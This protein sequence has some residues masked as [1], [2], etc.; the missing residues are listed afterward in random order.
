MK[1]QDAW[2]ATLGQLQLQMNKAAFDTWLRGAEVLAYQD[3]T[4]IISVRNAYAKDWLEQRL[5]PTI[6]RTL[7]DIFG[8]PVAVQFKI[9]A[10]ASS[11]NPGALLA[12]APL[13]SDAH[14]TERAENRLNGRYRFDSFVVGASNRLA[15]A[16]ALAVSENPGRAYNPL[17][18]HGGVGLGKTHLLHA[19][20]NACQE[21]GLSALY[22]TSE[23]FTNDLITAIRTQTQQ[24]LRDKYRTLDML[25]VD[26]VQ[27]IAGKESTQEEF[28]HTFNA[29]HGNDRQ[30]VM[31]SDRPPRAMATL[32]ERLCSRFEWGLLADIQ[33]P[34]FEMRLAILHAKAAQGHASVPPDALTLIAQRVQNNI[35]ELEGS[36]TR[37]MAYSQLTGRS[38]SLEVVESALVDVLP[39][40]HNLTPQAVVETVALYFGM[41]VKALTGRRRTRDVALPRQIAMFL[42]RQETDASLPQIGQALGGRDHTTVMYGYD[43]IASLVEKDERLCRQVVSIKERLY[44]GVYS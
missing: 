15:Q 27:F 34:D 23:E 44:Q 17:F 11:G 1:P 40:R 16:A 9:W 5:L 21:Q 38:I 28:F 26:D 20:G 39:R 18:V 14:G 36:L 13:L 33:P 37:L 32:E 2:Q 7:T 31:T 3:D 22:V 6:K 25:L 12:P 4:F 42:A 19:I 10:P 35:R 24:E 43:K 8:R 29:L 30:I 41:D